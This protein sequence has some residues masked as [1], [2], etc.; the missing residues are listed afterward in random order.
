M[1]SIEIK[2]CHTENDEANLKINIKHKIR[3]QKKVKENFINMASKEKLN[4][5]EV[6]I[7]G[8]EKED[9]C[10]TYGVVNTKIRMLKRSRN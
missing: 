9:N 10:G 6:F 4:F 8:Y 7:S 3:D 2:N 1:K 5:N